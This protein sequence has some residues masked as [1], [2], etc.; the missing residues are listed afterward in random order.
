L[1]LRIA[2][3]AAAVLDSGF[4]CGYLD[5]LCHNM[6]HHV[7]TMVASAPP[8]AGAE[9][10][11]SGGRKRRRPPAWTAVAA[12]V[13]ISAAALLLRHQL[14]DLR[15]NGNAK[16]ANKQEEDDPSSPAVFVH[17]GK[18]A[19]STITCH[20]SPAVWHSGM[21]DSGCGDAPDAG[22]GAAAAAASDS[23]AIVRRVVQRV[24]LQPAPAHGPYHA[25]LV[26]ARNPVD[27]IVSAYYYVHPD[28][29][30]AKKAHHKRGCHNFEVFKCW[31]TLQSLAEVGLAMPDTPSTTNPTERDEHCRSWAWDYLR[32]VRHCWHNYWNYNR[33]YGEL[34][35][36]HDDQQPQ[37][38]QSHIYVIRTEHAAEDW[39]A[40]D[41]LWGGTG[42]TPKFAESKNNFTAAGSADAGST[43]ATKKPDKTLSVEGRANLCRALCEEI[44]MYKRLLRAAANLDADRRRISIDELLRSCPNEVRGIRGCELQ[45]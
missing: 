34:L 32:G 22:P 18:T 41:Q 5:F 28:Y 17:L 11:S 15:T 13:S 45:T 44:Q 7:P 31:N 42:A 43:T 27:R 33:T 21:G 35:D 37:Q 24:H 9:R 25:Y 40:I 4:F 36:R 6:H 1:L 10:S 26:T 12:T 20:L 16:E 19:G 8:P 3:L 30:P 29:P 2:L 23:S 39:A 38:E 14:D